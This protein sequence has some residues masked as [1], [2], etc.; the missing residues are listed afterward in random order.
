[1]YGFY[2]YYG[3]DGK[4]AIH[5]QAI[6]EFNRDCIKYLFLFFPFN[7]IPDNNNE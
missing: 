6:Q 3:I 1:M 2:S 5:D 7:Q 4:Q